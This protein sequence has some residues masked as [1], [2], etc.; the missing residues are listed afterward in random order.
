VKMR[1][2]LAFTDIY[3]LKYVC[4]SYTNVVNVIKFWY[5]WS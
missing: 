3:E 1:H 2:L 5:S 4:I